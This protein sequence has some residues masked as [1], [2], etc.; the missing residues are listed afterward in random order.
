MNQNN[1]QVSTEIWVMQTKIHSRPSARIGT[2]RTSSLFTEFHISI[3]FLRQK[4]SYGKID[5]KMKSYHC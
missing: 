1:S 5:Q 3:I 2:A 4:N